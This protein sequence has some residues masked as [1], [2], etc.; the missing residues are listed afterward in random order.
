MSELG[1]PVAE[2]ANREL[3]RVVD[4]HGDADGWKAADIDG[5]TPAPGRGP[6]VLVEWVEDFAQATPARTVAA[7]EV[8]GDCAAEC[9]ST[10][11]AQVEDVIVSDPPPSL[12]VVHCDDCTTWTSQSLFEFT[13]DGIDALEHFELDEAFEPIDT[14]QELSLLFRAEVEFV[15]WA[16]G[17]WNVV[18]VRSSH[19]TCTSSPRTFDLWSVDDAASVRKVPK[20]MASLNVSD[21]GDDSAD[22]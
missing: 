3:S 11:D 10:I 16:D 22:C 9:R 6:L 8:Y 20:R 18:T 4:G 2:A 21:P 1:V 15:R 12:S 14:H 19:P 17:M 5:I 7:V 13:G